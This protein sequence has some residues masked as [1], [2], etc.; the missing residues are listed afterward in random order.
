MG[1]KGQSNA[2]KP[3]NG[4]DS[5]YRISFLL[6]LDIAENFHSHARERSRCA[7]FIVVHLPDKVEIEVIWYEARPNED[8]ALTYAGIPLFSLF[9]VS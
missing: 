6:H 1:S 7:Q 2:W 9:A 4:A 8:A 3:W 5:S